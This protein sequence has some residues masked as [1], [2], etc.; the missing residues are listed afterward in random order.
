VAKVKK[1]KNELVFPRNLY[2]QEGPERLY[3]KGIEYPYSTVLVVNKSEYDKSLKEGFY[4]DFGV[5]ILGTEDEPVSVGT[6]D[7]S[8]DF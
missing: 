1:I 8:E 5:V 7:D 4:D 6:A 3:S 2:K